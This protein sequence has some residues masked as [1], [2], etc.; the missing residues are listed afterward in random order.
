MA[1]FKDKAGGEWSIDL[2]VGDV[3]RLKDEADLDIDALAADPRAATALMV[4]GARPLAHALW[5]LCQDQAKDRGVSD[6]DFGFRLDREALD[7]GCDALLEAFLRFYQRSPAGRAIAAKLP[8]FLERMNRDIEA[9]TY[10]QLERELSRTATAS[11]ESAASTPS[12]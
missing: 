2:T 9:E 1:K 3:E 6:R 5:V 12:G 8:E 11:P 10:R 7:R 4:L